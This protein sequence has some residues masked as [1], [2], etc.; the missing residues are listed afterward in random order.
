[1]KNLND[2]TQ[3]APWLAS[4]LATLLAG[5][6]T[7]QA[8]SP[9]PASA[10]AA[11]AS[12]PAAS[13][14]GAA[15]AAPLP[16][17]LTAFAEV[18]REAKRTDGYLPVWTRDDRTWLEIPAEMLDKPFFFATS[19][20]SGLGE[21]RFWP[22]L[23][24]RSDM[25]VLRRVG[26]TVQLVARNTG[27]RAPEGTPLARAV[28]ESYSDSLLAA[29]P[30]AAAPHLQNKALLV[31]AS[32]LLGGDFIAAQSSLEQ[33]YRVSYALDRA[34]SHFERVRPTP[35]GTYFTVRQHFSVP[36]LPP[37]PAFG[38]TPPN[39][40]ALPNPPSTVPDARSLFV[41]VAYTLAPLPAVPL[42]PRRADPRVGYF[43]RGV[44][45][46]ADDNSEG[47]R[48]HQI[49]R[50]RLEKKDPAAAV[51][52]PKEP[53]RV[54]MD[55]NIP[56]KWR[57]PVRAGILEWNKA[58]ERAGFRNAIVV[59]QQAADAD[60]TSFEGTRMLAVRWFAQ[61][62]PGATA[63]GPSQADPRTGELLRGAAIIPENWVRIYRA[64]AAETVPRFSAPLDQ[65]DPA[66][67][68][69][70]EFSERYMACTYA[71]DALEETQFAFELL[72]ERGEIDPNG[73]DGER[74]IAGALK[75]VTM[76]EVGHALGLRHNFRASVGITA[77]QL[78]DPAFTAANG[79]SNSV[80]DYN[81]SNV[82]LDGERVA[83]YHMDTLGAYDYWAIEYGYRQ[84]AN[85]EEEKAALAQLAA[86][87]E[88]DPALAYATDEDVFGIDPLVNQ[89][90]L[91]NDPLAFAQRQLKLSRELWDRVARRTLKSDDDLTIYRR[92]LG[93][94]FLNF[95]TSLPLATHYIG[96]VFTS[97]AMAGA[98]QA[99]LTP[100]PAAKQRAALDLV[101]GEVFS[102]QSF[103]FDPKIMS[104]LGVDQFE[105][106][107]AGRSTDFSLPGTVLALQRSAL[108]TLMSDMLAARLADAE[109]KVADP[110]T[111]LS[112]AEVQERLNDAVWSELKGVKTGAP[113][114]AIE[115]D[116]LRRNLQREHVRRLASG[117]LRASA[118][119]AD[120]RSV[121]RM[122][123]LQLQTR[124]Q[125][126]LAGGK[127]SSLVRAHLEDSLATLTEALKA[128]L[129]KQ[130]V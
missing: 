51:S 103:R 95:S 53:I 15:R 59:D 5:C 97:R 94:V 99:L 62:G 91:G 60:W 33:Q 24:G 43:T 46:F 34:N 112:Y 45:D 16:G 4:A 96:G 8:P 100:V 106:G 55:R 38:S 82:P 1:M 17:A 3:F 81:A 56:E 12:A 76:H 107:F 71:Q 87:S 64:R 20:A 84:Y 31:D 78:R 14:S 93:R 105:R 50:W 69:P 9:G 109:S 7:A 128:P 25:V 114:R 90:D 124:L 130:G 116:S 79:V 47:R 39:P 86:R 41:S 11:A 110:R 129:V 23:M 18:V 104:R 123:A 126:A 74:F 44:T 101:V 57:E 49:R 42:T 66:R 63:V 73:P 30:L 48:A 6:A 19:I 125:A 54:V 119:A 26:N 21:G 61:E 118:Q 108:D 122:A 120:V 72:A 36:R 40:A 32:V 22:G 28:A 70:G 58:F 83:S 127:S 80:M 10:P 37:L 102:S 88:K 52:E 117:V 13:A 27:V 35:A 111:L 121:H 115:I 77:E 2:P 29:A 89:R 113:G 68:Q 65:G 92:T 85:A 67:I 75:D 98:D